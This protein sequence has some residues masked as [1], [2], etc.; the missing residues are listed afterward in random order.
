MVF[1]ACSG[2]PMPVSRYFA[3]FGAVEISDTEIGIPGDGTVR[4]WRRE[5][6]SGFVFSAL[7]P[8][9]FPRSGFARTEEN[10]AELAT[11]A[12]FTE[13]LQAQAVV[14]AAPP[15]LEPT[16]ANRAAVKSFLGILPAGFPQPVL[17]FPGWPMDVVARA[18][19][20]RAVV[21]WDPLLDDPA[22]DGPLTYLRLP[23]PAGHRSRY[24]DEA[25]AAVA[26][27]CRA[28]RSDLVFCVFRNADMHVNAKTLERLLE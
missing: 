10:R 25:I 15:E 11:F 4:R 24:D 22:P 20:K 6:R 19:G 14:F 26:E 1:V 27:R 13:K 7:A 18:A 9:S 8:R 23:G 28:A 5:C 3:E 12:G 2:F 21:A 16:K 17:D